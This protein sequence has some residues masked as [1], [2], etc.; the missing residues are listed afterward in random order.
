M[1]DS[2]IM[3]IAQ[4]YLQ[5]L[6]ESGI[7]VDRGVIFGSHAR[8]SATTWS[9]ID[10]LVVSS[11]FDSQRTREELNVLWRSAAREDARIEPVPCGKNEWETGTDSAIVEIARREGLEVTL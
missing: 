11:R 1:A 3:R 9:D 5:K 8:G 2:T 4:C 7:P 10:L 6:T